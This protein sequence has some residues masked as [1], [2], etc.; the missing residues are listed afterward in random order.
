MDRR[1]PLPVVVSAPLQEHLREARVSAEKDR[2][3]AVPGVYL[4]EAIGRKYP[5]AGT[6]W[7]WQWVF[8]SPVLSTDPRGGVRRRHHLHPGAVN[9]TIVRAVKAAGIVKH[10]TAHSFRHAFATH[11]LED[12]QDI[13]T[14]QELLGHADVATTMSYTHALNRGGL[15]VRSPADRLLGESGV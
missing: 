10:A 12:G 6:Q 4:P 14:V 1:V 3:A 2:A 8:P 9:R 13:R 15:G 11:L 5:D 7:G